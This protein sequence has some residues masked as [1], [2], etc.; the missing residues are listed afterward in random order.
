MCLY[1]SE[2]VPSTAVNIAVKS[3]AVALI[4]FQWVTCFMIIL[5]QIQPLSVI[6][7][8]LLGFGVVLFLTFWVKFGSMFKLFTGKENKSFVEDPY[9]HPLDRDNTINP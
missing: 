5:A 6:C 8:I 4:L 9:I 3:Y 2:S 1:S 7:F